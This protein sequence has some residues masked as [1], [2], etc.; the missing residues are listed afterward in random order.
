MIAWKRL[1]SGTT[2]ISKRRVFDLID[3]T[4][5]RG[6]TVWM[7]SLGDE[8]LIISGSI[9]PRRDNHSKPVNAATLADREAAEA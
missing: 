1:Q 5:P 3:E 2:S 8:T 6:V 4:V 7:V 9:E